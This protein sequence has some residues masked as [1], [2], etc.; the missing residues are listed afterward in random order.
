MSILLTGGAGYIGSHTAVE[1]L[2]AGEDI[3]I[4]DNL[5]NSKIDM[6]D[7]IKKI[8]NNWSIKGVPLMTQIN[9]STIH[10]IGFTLVIESNP[11]S[12]P[13]GRDSIRVNMNNKHVVPK[14][15]NNLSVTAE[16]LIIM[17]RLVLRD[18]S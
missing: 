10:L 12:N 3:I 14:P 9:I 16:K 2:N 6:I 15:S 7:K 11:K 17:L 1:L 4:V 5:S 18:L 8:T 13:K